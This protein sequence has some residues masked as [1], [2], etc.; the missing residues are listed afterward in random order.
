M[1]NW[2]NLYPMGENGI[3]Y[4]LYLQKV[5][6]KKVLKYLQWFGTLYMYIVHVR[7]K[8]ANV[9][10]SVNSHQ[11]KTRVGPGFWLAQEQNWQIVFWTSYTV[12][13]SIL[14]FL[15]VSTYM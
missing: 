5:G 13:V 14:L 7:H 12:T 4:A 11:A 15:F 9:T 6:C 8:T 10:S 2:M 3:C 1:E